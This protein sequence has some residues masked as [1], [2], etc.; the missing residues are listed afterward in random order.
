MTSLGV[1]LKNHG[2]TGPGFDIVRLVAASTVLISHSFPLTQ[3]NNSNEPLYSL[4]GGQ[5]TLGT[6]AVGVFFATS[7]FLIAGSLTRSASIIDFAWRRSVRILPG[8]ALVTIVT[9]ILIGP[10]LSDR[11]LIQYYF[12]PIT[13]KYLL[14]MV[15]IYQNNLPGVFELN[16][17]K[18]AV[19]G[20]L[21]TLL[22]EVLSYGSLLT[23]SKMYPKLSKVLITIALVL[24]F[25][26][27]PLLFISHR[28]H[29]FVELFRYF[30]AGSALFLWRNS[31]PYSPWLASAC[32]IALAAGFALKLSFVASPLSVAYLAVAIGM[33]KLPRL[34]ADYSY[35]IYLWA[36]PTQQMMVATCGAMSWW[37]NV[38]LS[39][40]FVFGLAVL[41]WTFVEAPSMRLKSLFAVRHATPERGH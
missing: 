28:L 6:L 30:C 11:T 25:V 19:N 24:V 9:A 21:W 29:Q 2:G 34:K 40:P 26:V 36:F 41:S 32:L 13:Y 35:G 39:A 7:G 27:D 14:N 38:S 31:V 15:F 12:D 17:Y 18:R 10:I 37:G 8:L 33:T 4:T 1:T 3:G 5:M 22:Y 23:L 20:S 16:P